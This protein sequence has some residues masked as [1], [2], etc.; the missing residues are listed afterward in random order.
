MLLIVISTLVIQWSVVDWSSN[1]ALFL[2]FIAFYGLAYNKRI[3]T[4]AL[5]Q[6]ITS[7]LVMYWLIYTFYLDPRFGAYP[8]VTAGDYMATLFGGSVPILAAIVYT[9]KFKQN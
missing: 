3:W 2:G 5:W 6:V 9:I 1:L 7:I 4:K 8:P